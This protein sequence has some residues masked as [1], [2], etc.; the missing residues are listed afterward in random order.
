VNARLSASSARG[1]RRFAG[2]SREAFEALTAVAAQTSEDAERLRALGAAN[3]QVTGNLKFDVALNPVQLELGRGRRSA[4]GT[5]RVLL[6]A[7]TRNGE[8][9][10]LLDALPLLPAD[11]LLVIVP[12]HPQRFDAVA[13]LIEAKRIAHRRVSTGQPLAPDTRVLLG[14]SMGEMIAHYAA[15]DIAFVGGSLL[16]FGGQNLI[17]ACAIG[18]PV[19]LGPHTYNFAEAAGNAIEAG[20]AL[21][22]GTAEEVM[23]KAAELF[24]DPVTLE[25]MG[26]RGVEFTRAHRGA[27]ERVMRMFEGVMQK[28]DEKEW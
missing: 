18:K 17:E 3:V 13:A 24:A 26:Q 23:R 21:R 16:P 1:Y 28:S 6:A 10:L 19:L 20:A 22:V 8:E 15:C 2:L 25:R 11:V 12:R 14:D 9:A 7:S 27:T 4:Y 5:R